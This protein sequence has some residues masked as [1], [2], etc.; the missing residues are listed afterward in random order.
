MKQVAFFP[1]RGLVFILFVAYNQFQT[2]LPTMQYEE[3]LPW[4]QAIG[5]SYHLGV[6]GPGM[7]MLVLSGLI[8][9]VSVLASLGIRERVRSYFCLLLLTQACITGAIVARDMFVL[10][11]F[12]GAVMI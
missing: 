1:N 2:F 4:L 7:V 6:D 12:W 10:I 11:L 9:I 3:K 5:V 8:G